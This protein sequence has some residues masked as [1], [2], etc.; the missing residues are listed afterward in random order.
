MTSDSRD[1]GRGITRRA[2]IGG[3]AGAAAAAAGARSAPRAA[4]QPARGK[5]FA[6]KALNVFMFDHPYPR[7]LK[8]L[9]PQFT[10]QTGI[11]VEMDTPG[12]L[13]YNQRADLELST[14]SGAYDVMALTFIFSGKWIGAGWASR[15]NDYIARDTG[16]DAGDFLSG[17][18][19]PMKSGADVFALPFVAESTLM[20]YRRDAF[21][22]AGLKP[23]DTFDDLLAAAPKIQTP[24]M[25]AYMGRG[26]GGFHWIWPNYLFAYGGRFFADPPNDLTPML[27]SAES[28]RSADVFGRLYREFSVP[29]VQSYAEPQSS[30]GMMEGRAGVYIDA[31]AWVGLA[32]DP[33]KS[34]VKDRV[35][36]AL[37][38]GGPA[39]RFPQA[40]VHGLQ[41]PAGAKQKDV[42]WEFVRWA[43]SKEVMARISESV[44]YPAVTRASVLGSPAYRGKYNWGGADIGA[45]HGAV[46]KQAGAGYM[47]YRT[48]PEFPPVG[49]RVS[50]ALSEIST[51]QKPAA[52]AMRDAQHDVEGILTKAGRSIRK[53]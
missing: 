28:I 34:K 47:A 46:L 11:K 16:V 21:E 40:A 49:D 10:E 51:G 32:A 19:A 31:L 15:L 6:G 25:K 27:A 45:L 23:P 35:G 39:G 44:I 30:G 38:P 43:T 9:L 53:S 26:L 17:A 41:I 5:P 36:F 24:E 42:S 14:G 2:F 29:G 22:R 37:P 20:V 4:A 13:V 1:P 8:E 18:M 48:V 33:V 52:T 50:I 12:F 7:A 3:A